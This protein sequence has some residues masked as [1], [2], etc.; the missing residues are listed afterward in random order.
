MT[1]TLF[2][3]TR[4]S[5]DRVINTLGTSLLSQCA[6]LDLNILNG[7][8]FGQMSSRFTYISIHG[9]SVV[10]YII[11]SKKN[12]YFCD[13]L[14]VE[15]NGTST[16]T[17]L[18]GHFACQ[19]VKSSSNISAKTVKKIKWSNSLTPIYVSLLETEDIKEYFPENANI[20]LDVNGATDCIT[21][22]C[23]RAAEFMLHIPRN[24]KPIID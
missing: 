20:H 9:N 12:R 4:E 7:S 3:N 11:T 8:E 10:D 21:K 23:F 15:E 5:Q 24:G 6:A 22:I 16:H 2:D 17:P 19:P 18:V 14:N 1:S 13:Q